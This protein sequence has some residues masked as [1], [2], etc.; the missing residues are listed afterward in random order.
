MSS[1]LTVNDPLAIERLTAAMDRLGISHD[2]ND[3]PLRGSED[4]GR[5][6]SDGTR[7]AMMFV[8]SGETCP[9][10]H[11]PDFDFPDGL[12][13]VGARLFQQVMTDILG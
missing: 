8:G 12:I 2:D 4:F 7:M 13:A 3:L 1:D 6:G 11:N 9:Q 5:F 10:L